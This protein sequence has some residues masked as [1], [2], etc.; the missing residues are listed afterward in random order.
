[1]WGL[2]PYCNQEQTLSKGWVRSFGPGPSAERWNNFGRGPWSQSWYRCQEGEVTPP[3]TRIQTS[4]GNPI[5]DTK[6]GG[7]QD[8]GSAPC[9]HLLGAGSAQGGSE[10]ADSE[11]GEGVDHQGQQDHEQDIGVSQGIPAGICQHKRDVWVGKEERTEGAQA[12]SQEGAEGSEEEMAPGVKCQESSSRSDNE[13]MIYRVG[14]S[15]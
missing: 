7:Q 11:Q 10:G 14:N 8:P 5:P 4:L 13:E 9:P 3:S 15:S 12:P 1:M 6:P 2:S